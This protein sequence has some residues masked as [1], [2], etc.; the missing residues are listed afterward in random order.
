MT[1][2]PYVISG[3]QRC[4]SE[5][6]ISALAGKRNA[7]CAAGRRHA[8]A[9]P[10]VQ[11][12]GAR[13]HFAGT[14]ADDLARIKQAFMLNLSPRLRTLPIPA[15]LRTFLLLPIEPAGQWTSEL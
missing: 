6:L 7:P 1:F 13:N 2:R 14:I 3:T 8:A 10:A 12:R 15:R 5:W 4:G 11:R 9:A